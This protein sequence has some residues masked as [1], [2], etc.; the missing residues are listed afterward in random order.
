MCAFFD[1][2]TDLKKI[3]K[4]LEEANINVSYDDIS[5]KFEIKKNVRITNQTLALVNNQGNPHFTVMGW[6]IKFN[7]KSPLIFNSRIET[8][9][10]EK[11]WQKIFHDGRCLIPMTGFIEYRKAEDD[12]I[13]VSRWKKEHKIKRNT[14]FRI[15]IPGQPF[16]FAPAIYIKIN[17]ICFYSIITTPPPPAV[18]AIPYKRCLAIFAYDNAV[19]FLFNESGYCME[20]V[21]VYKGELEV[22]E[23]FKSA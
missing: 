18:K 22:K 3:K 16:F 12:P 6:G 4:K 7:E 23:L 20:K 2:Y 11:R 21:T 1:I 5:D 8:I 19:D 14:P 10:T 15:N 17:E 9:N 13:E